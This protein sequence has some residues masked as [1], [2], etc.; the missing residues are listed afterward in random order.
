V[1]YAY[2]S[3]NIQTKEI[4]QMNPNIRDALGLQSGD[5]GFVNAVNETCVPAWG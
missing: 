4:S 2:E 5:I 1:G 3:Y